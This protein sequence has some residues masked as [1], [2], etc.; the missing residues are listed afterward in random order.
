MDI[1]GK[2]ALVTGGAI[3]VGRSIALG[4]AQAGADVVIAYHTSVTEA[5]ATVAEIHALGVAGLA[6]QADV[7]D[8]SQVQALVAQIQAAFGR[9]DIVV[10]SSSRFQTTPV[11]TTTIEEWRQVLGVLLDGPFFLAQAAAPL[12]QAQGA[13]VIINILDL[14]A[15]EP[16]PNFIAHSVGKSGLL[17]LTRGLA[18]ELA[19]AI[20]VNAVAPGAVLAPSHYDPQ[21][22]QQVADR[23]LLKRWGSPQD[24]ADAVVFLARADYITGETLIVDGGEQWGRPHKA[25]DSQLNQ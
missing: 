3:R 25:S 1:Q 23:T 5:Q 22:L 9:L 20:R 8:V 7:S 14:S 21:K 6:I 17:A 4:L 10:N 16:W 12:M 11:M 19:P 18:L 2:V 24:V 15:F 13:G